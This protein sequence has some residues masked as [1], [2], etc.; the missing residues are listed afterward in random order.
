MYS[1]QAGLCHWY[2]YHW[3]LYHGGRVTFGLY[4]GEEYMSTPCGLQYGNGRVWLFHGG[5]HGSAVPKCRLHHDG[6][7]EQHVPCGGCAMAELCPSLRVG[8]GG[9]LCHLVG[10]A[11]GCSWVLHVVG[12]PVQREWLF[13]GMGRQPWGLSP[14]DC[15]LGDVIAMGSCTI[16]YTWVPLPCRCTI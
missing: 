11:G 12:D 15:T 8:V 9:G 2:I 4:Q 3:M 6:T 1:R 13:H 5:S 10:A 7:S 14:E 16:V